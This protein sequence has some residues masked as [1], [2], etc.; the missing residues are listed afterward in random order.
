MAATSTVETV[1]AAPREQVFK[2]FSERDSI[3]ATL[4]IQ[5]SLK[6]PGAG[7]PSGVGAQYVLGLAGVGVTEETVELVPGERMVYKVIG[8]AP[9]KN[10]VGTIV[11][12][13]APGGTRVVYTM[14]SEPSLSVPGK[15]LEVGLKGLINVLIGGV[16]KAAK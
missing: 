5:V 7:I 13:D 8:G 15:V 10:H 6:K 11:F 16:R 4:P 1:I 9:V 2:L 12:S 3:N 14:V